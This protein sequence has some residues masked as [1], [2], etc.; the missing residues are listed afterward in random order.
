MEKETNSSSPT[1]NQTTYSLFPIAYLDAINSLPS[2][3]AYKKKSYD[4]LEA[5]EGDYLLDVGCGTGDDV[6]ALAC[7]VGKTGHVVGV[8]ANTQMVE[9]AIRRSRG[10]DLKVDFHHDKADKLQFKNETFH[11]CRVDRLLHQLENPKPILTEL[12]RVLRPDGIVVIVEPD[13]GTIAIDGADI[14]LSRDIIYHAYSS[15][16][17]LC[18]RQL[19]RMFA[20]AELTDIVVEASTSIFTDFELANGLFHLQEAT[21]LLVKKNLLSE[22]KA[23]SWL[24]SLAE[25]SKSARFFCSMTGF[26]VK[27]KKTI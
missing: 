8:D 7:I 12:I 3:Q 19:Y 17:A 18:G 11:G 20:E 1:T 2:T 9:E 21:N 5:H 22:D 10:L 15:S 27:G 23:L 4:L 16:K 26:S 13:F 14:M 25:A 24:K 6:R